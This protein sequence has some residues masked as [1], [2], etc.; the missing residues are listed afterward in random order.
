M[1]LASRVNLKSIALPTEHG[2]WSFLAEPIVLGLLVAPTWK[3]FVLGLAIVSLFLLHQPLK[4]AMKDNLN[5][6]QYRA[7]GWMVTD[8]SDNALVDSSCPRCYGDYLCSD[9]AANGS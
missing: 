5:R 8:T 3:G 4:I 2:G 6:S 7:I 9:T 1:A